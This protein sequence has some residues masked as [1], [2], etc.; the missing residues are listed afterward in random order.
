MTSRAGQFGTLSVALAILFIASGCGNKA[1]GQAPPAMPPA[2]ITA[3]PVSVRTVP[4]Y[5]DEIGRCVATEVVSIQPQASGR[6]TEVFFKDGADVKKGDRLFTIDPRPFQ[7]QLQQ[8][9][10]ALVENKAELTR[11]EANLAQEQA[12]LGRGLAGINE[13][14]ARLELSKLEFERAKELVKADAV[15]RQQ[16]DEKKMGVSVSEAQLKSSQA[17]MSMAQAQV[18]HAEAEVAV[19]RAKVE[20]SQAAIASAKLNLEYTTV[21]SPIDGRAGQ[22]LVDVGNVV[23]ATFNPVS[24]VVLQRIDPIYVDFTVPEAELSRVR[25]L[26]SGRTLKV[27]V[28]PADSPDALHVGEFSFLDN[29]VQQSSGTIK[30]RATV[31][32][33]ERALW[34]GQ[35]VRVRLI[36]AE[37]QN[38]ILVP[39]RAIQTGQAGRFVYVVKP[40]ATVE[41][42]VVKPGQRH[43]DDILISEGLKEGERI[44]L[45]GHLTLYPGAKVQEKQSTPEPAPAAAATTEKASGEGAK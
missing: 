1:V 34:P 22:R 4:L 36:L 31:Q 3:V 35:F 25:K 28:R 23:S 44:V 24:L 29:A 37:L 33:R 5:I 21:L 42:R 19:A 10:A 18:R 41:M 9:E 20:S 38:S 8:A 32:N 26:M 16:F 40:D 39:A 45:A 12:A 11:A 14:Q 15:A 2:M 6:I 7:V 13:M 17:A 27:E 43:G 30:L